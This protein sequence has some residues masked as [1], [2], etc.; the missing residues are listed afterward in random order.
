MDHQ[1]HVSLLGDGIPNPGGIWADF[2]SGNGAFT[3]ALA[4][5]IGPKGIIYSIDKNQQS[6]D[7]QRRALQ[8]Q[9][10]AIT[11][12]YLR[13]DFARP[14][15]LPP[16]DGLVAANALHFLKQKDETIRL[17]QNYLRPGGRFLLVEYDTDRGNH[18]VPHPF[19]YRTWQRITRQN[20]LQRTELLAIVPSSF[21]G[22]FYAAVSYAPT[23]GGRK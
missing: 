11:V 12:H 17:L 15:D 14:L 21:L 3:L 22:Q 19:S 20:G 23:A 13:S 6:L 4:E 18:W 2:G 8:T 1:D 5:L 9:Y 7:Q 10:P 16:L